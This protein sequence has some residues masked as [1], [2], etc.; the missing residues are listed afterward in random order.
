MKTVT[1]NVRIYP[2]RLGHVTRFTS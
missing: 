1:Q 2:V